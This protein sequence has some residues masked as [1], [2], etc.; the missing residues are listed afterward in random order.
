MSPDWVWPSGLDVLEE[1][2]QSV[3]TRARSAMATEGML[4]ALTRLLPIKGI[5]QR[6]AQV[7]MISG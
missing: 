2:L 7:W 5:G 4:G 3:G 6:A 1:M